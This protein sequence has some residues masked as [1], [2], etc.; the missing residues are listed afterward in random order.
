MFGLVVCVSYSCC[1]I[2]VHFNYCCIAICAWFIW[3]ETT[4]V[5]TSERCARLSTN[6]LQ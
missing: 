3:C 5:I 4:P 1:A 6:H 2:I